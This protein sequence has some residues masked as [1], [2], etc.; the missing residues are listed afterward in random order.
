MGSEISIHISDSVL[1]LP[2]CFHT[3]QDD[4]PQCGYNYIWRLSSDKPHHMRGFDYS[5]HRIDEICVTIPNSIAKMIVV[6]LAQLGQIDL[7]SQS[8]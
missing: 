4:P 6:Y 7:F 1:A 3:G 5:K 8:G 2:A